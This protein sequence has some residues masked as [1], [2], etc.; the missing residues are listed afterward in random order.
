MNQPWPEDRRAEVR[1]LVAIIEEITRIDDGRPD[2][3]GRFQAL[4]QRCEA[5]ICGGA[6][7][8]LSIGV[9]IAAA[10][11]SRMSL[12]ERIAVEAAW[13]VVTEL[14][15]LRGGALLVPQLRKLIAAAQLATTGER[16]FTKW[17]VELSEGRA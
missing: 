7:T 3:L 15:T 4:A 10:R 16:P 14:V 13:G 6:V 5:L 8:R 17:I 2:F 11:L 9:W 1:E 12:P